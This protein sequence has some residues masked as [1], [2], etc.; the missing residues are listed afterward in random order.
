MTSLLVAGTP[1]LATG[2]VPENLHAGPLA[3]SPYLNELVQPG[4]RRQLNPA[5]PWAADPAKEHNHCDG[6]SNQPQSRAG[7]SMPPASATAAPASTDRRLPMTEE[8]RGRITPRQPPQTI[9]FPP[10]VD[11]SNCI[12]L[13]AELHAAIRPG[14]AIV[15]ADLTLTEFCDS[16]G[17]GV[18]VKAWKE[19]QVTGTDLRIVMPA[20]NVR[21]ILQITGTDK[22]LRIYPRI[23]AALA[24]DEL[25]AGS[26]QPGTV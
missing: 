23:G 24:D 6:L 18:L 15:I 7:C 25:A 8:E 14:V 26:G 1:A 11:I 19:A 22:V 10:E 2:H 12:R 17:V 21:R 4:C 13:G 3:N 9:A 16:A 5:K 20:G